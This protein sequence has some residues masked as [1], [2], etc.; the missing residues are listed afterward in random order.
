[1]QA[2]RS[3]FETQASLTPASMSNGG[4]ATCKPPS[5]FQGVDWLSFGLTGLLT[6]AVFMAT[7]SP[8][9]TLEMSGILAT[10]ANYGGVA[11]PPGFPLWTLYAWLFKT[12][13]PFSNIA[14][15]IAVSNAVASSLTC[16]MIALVVSKM[17]KMMLEG[18]FRRGFL[19]PREVSWLRFVSGAIAGM[20]YGFNGLVWQTSVVVDTAP[21]SICLFSL[22][23]CLLT[24]WAH[25]PKRKRYLYLAVLV[26]GLAI[27]AS[28][29]LL[30]AALGLPFFVMFVEMAIARELFFAS[31]VAAGFIVI[32]SRTGSFRLLNEASY[33]SQHVYVGIALVTFIAWI[34]LVIK[35]RSAFIEWRHVVAMGLLAL[36]GVSFFMTLPIASMT[37]PPSN[38]GY[39]RTQEGFFHVIS[40]GQF[41]RL[42]VT[43]NVLLLATQLWDYSTVM[44]KR[45]GVIP[46]LAALVPFFLLGRIYKTE[47]TII[48]GFLSFYLCLSIL[49]TILLNPTPDRGAQELIERFYMPSFVVLSIWSGLGL[50]IVAAAITR[51][52]DTNE[53]A[54]HSVI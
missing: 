29:I 14:W 15:R 24:T 8:E 2:E 41:E 33:D 37:N 28:P 30:P 16:G 48:C 18:T 21:L 12:I 11:H 13:L 53:T 7:L 3:H 17:G 45:A 25:V 20:S 50:T 9:L 35:T 10:A 31:A 34:C 38:W 52:S 46:L 51:R 19:R 26:F 23:L 44:L 49:M 6:F 36:V 40:R 4:G 54:E 47:R 43:K 1:M 42:S 22:V 27:G 32:G 5:V 39:A